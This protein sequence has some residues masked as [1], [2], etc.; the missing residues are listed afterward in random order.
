MINFKNIRYKN[1]LSTG[2]AFIEISLDAAKS[3]LCHG[4][5]GAGK[6]TFIEA[7]SFALYGKSFRKTNK[8]QLINSINKKDL[9]VE[10]EFT[11][12]NREY[13]IRRGMKPNIF[14]IY[15]NS[16]SYLS[17]LATLNLLSEISKKN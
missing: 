13:M 17:F 1:I 12:N 5:N 4:V 9:L 10:I 14:E 6:S 15:E 7:I 3:T 16:S 11:A 8:P 2:N